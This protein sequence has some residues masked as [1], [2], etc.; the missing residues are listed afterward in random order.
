MVKGLKAIESLLIMAIGATRQH[1][2]VVGIFVTCGAVL[3]EAD[4]PSTSLRDQ[5]QLGVHVALRAL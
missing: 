4:I 3:L 1:H 5:D 2:P